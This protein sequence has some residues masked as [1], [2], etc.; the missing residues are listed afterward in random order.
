[1][2]LRCLLLPLAALAA[3]TAPPLDLGPVTETHIMVPMRDGV[4]LSTYLYTPKG[5][6]PWPVLYEQRYASLRGT[7]ARK[8]YAKLAEA[9]FVVAAQNF[10]GSQLSEGVFQGYRALGWGKLQDGYDSVEWLAKR[11]WSTGK[12]GTFGGSQAGYAQNF[13]AVTRPPHLTAQYITDG[14]L[15]LFHLGYRRGGVT[16]PQRF[17]SSM[18]SVARDPAEGRRHLED[19]FAHPNY[20]SYWQ[21]EDCTI[22]FGAMNVPAFA[23]ASWFDFM[24]DGSIETYIGRQ[25]RGGPQA[26]GSQ[27][28]LIGPW[29]HGGSKSNKIAELEFP[30]NAA[31]DLDAHM[32]RWFDGYLKGKQTGVTGD[33]A[34]RYYVMGANV[35][36]TA[37]DWPVPSVATPY[38]LHLKTLDRKRPG[39]TGSVTGGATS[40]VA[41]P[42]NPA[43]QP[44]AN[45]PTARDSRHY[46]A[47]PEVR[48]FTTEPLT[49]PVEWTGKVLAELHVSSTAPDSDFIVRVN[50]VYPD[51]RSILLIN[52]P[53]RA[54]YRDSFEKPA[55]MKKGEIY[56]MIVNVG[57]LSQVFAPGHRIRVTIASTMADHFEANPNTGEPAAIEPPK[58]MFVAR[59]TIWHDANHASR[60]IAPVVNG[61]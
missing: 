15:S 50:D 23:L 26:R 51:G 29:L 40:Y 20:D 44:G 36:R 19:Q 31:F 48:T 46:E 21:Q 57:W 59:N 42:T 25:H 33:P 53:R 45:E 47:H 39:V 49:E 18:A 41:D 35:W 38:Y 6:G 1:M 9:G 24:A 14:G 52:A 60:I 54:R 22:H 28:L 43:P 5:N 7:A 16:R 32:I 8:R 27:Q 30:E 10:R 4:G 37:K 34:I 61:K 12:I 13:L 11:P 2:K 55:L 17:L 58:R 56:K 3:D